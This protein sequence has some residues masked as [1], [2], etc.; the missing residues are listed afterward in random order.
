VVVG[1]AGDARKVPE[2]GLPLVETGV[3]AA[4]VEEE[5]LGVALDEPAAIEGLDALGLHGLEG[6]GDVWVGG[7]LW[8]DLHGSGLVGERADE[9]VSVAKL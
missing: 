3:H 2:V 7:L 1:R 5:D 6:A 9:A 4:G 8:L